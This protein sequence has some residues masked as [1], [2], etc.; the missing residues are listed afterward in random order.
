MS[1]VEQDDGC[2]EL[3]GGKEVCGDFVIARRDP[4][5]LFEF[6]EEAFDK[7]ALLVEREVA[8]SSDGS[9]AFGGDHR[10]DA[11]LEKR[12]DQAI[13]IEGFVADHGLRVGLGEQG[14]RRF[15]IVRLTWREGQRDWVAERVDD[16]M[17]LGRQA[18]SGAAEG[19]LFAPFLRAP[20]L[21]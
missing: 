6:I 11:G 3:D 2:G 21:C 18:A 4:S 10:R 1:S 8:G 7:V 19:L 12:L 5:E 20:A 14:E 17:D 9:V 16:G 15:E 13:G